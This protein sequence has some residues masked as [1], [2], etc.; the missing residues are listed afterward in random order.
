VNGLDVRE[1]VIKRLEEDLLGPMTIDEI[2][3]DRPSDRYLTGILFPQRT[4]VGNEQDEALASEGGDENEGAAAE[5]SVTLANTMRPASAGLSFA[6]RPPAGKDPAIALRISCG[7]Y[8]GVQPADEA[9]DEGDNSRSTRRKRVVWQ[10]TDHR[11]EVPPIALNFSQKEILLDEYEL[12]GL[13]VVIR[14][15]PWRNDVLVTVALVNANRH[16]RDDG[17]IEAEQRS[18]FQVKLE[19]IPGPGTSLPSRPSRKSTVDEDG[20]SAAL[21]YR[22]ARE[23]AV[24]HTCSAEWELSD[25]HRASVVRTSWLPRSRLESVSTAGHAVFRSLRDGRRVSPLSTAT[26]SG[27][28]APELVA[29]LSELP[30]AYEG[31]IS[32]QESRVSG[33]EPALQGQARLHMEVC[34]RTLSRMRGGITLLGENEQVRAAFM[35]ANRAMLIQRRWAFADEPDL[36][37]RPFQLGFLLLSL[38]SVASADH[39]DRGTMDLLWF[40]TGGGKTEA[41]LGLIAFALFLRRLRH[42]GGPDRGAGVAA[43]MRYTLR[44]L[45]TQQFQRAAALI[46]AC[47]HLRRGNEVPTGL[48]VNLGA[49]PFSLG[50]WVGK[51]AV[52]N[53]VAEALDALE[54]RLP[55]TPAQIE[56]CPACGKRLRWYGASNRTSVR[57]EC[58]NTACPIGLWRTHIPIWTVD[59]DVYREVPSLVIGTIDKFAQ[60]TRKPESGVLFGLGKPYDPPDLIIQDELHLISGPLGTMAAVYEI[61]IDQLCTREG[62]RPKIIGSTATIRR[63]AEQVR[64]LFDRETLQFPPPGIDADDSCFAVRD[65]GANVREYVGTTTAGRSAK[66][67]LQ[68]VCAS[69]LQSAGSPGLSDAARDPYY[70]LVAYFNALR[71][72]GGAL[73]LMQDDVGDSLRQFAARRAETAREVAIIEELTSRVTQVE[74]RDKLRQLGYPAGNPEVIDVVLASN[75]ISVGVDILRLGLMVV[76][77]QPKGIA[78]YIQATSRVGRGNLPGLVVTIY[79]NGKARDR[80]HYETFRTWHSTLYREVESTSVTPFASRARDR[81]LHAALVAMVRHLLP[82]MKTDPILKAGSLSGIAELVELIVRRAGR[83]DPEETTGVELQLKEIIEV[84]QGRSGLRR[85]WNDQQRNTSLLISAEKAAA[86]RAAGRAMGTAWP[87]PNSMRSVEPGTPF[88]VVEALRVDVGGDNGAE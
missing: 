75:M 73:V 80:S 45:T 1:L 7:T 4:E 59:D 18:F 28:S 64:A 38:A 27:A 67:T 48:D 42:L 72:L 46:I 16:T 11:V 78:E 19:V 71:E 6:V 5:E 25:G 86:L 52:P 81:S 39:P 23:F 54:R 66:F 21:L 47:E 70:T 15:T 68:A 87:T 41:Y 83:I 58:Q 29:A 60:I 10:R 77:G 2:L 9:I 40:P 62:H 74:I 85:Y 3:T 57:V 14:V 82:G 37:W 55:T 17:R 22:E 30:N 24:G 79:N 33:L 61:A 34:R 35:L 50:L 53:T 26:L 63:A 65:P 76:N 13:R 43:F 69:L 12:P 36:E 49:I 51:E 31:W 56:Q 84:W 8:A 44:L 20:R 32:L 88:T